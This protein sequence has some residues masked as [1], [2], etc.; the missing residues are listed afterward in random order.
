VV[1]VLIREHQGSS[2]HRC[3]LFPARLR[4]LENLHFQVVHRHIRG[5]QVAI[6][7]VDQAPHRFDL[8]FIILCSFNPSGENRGIRSKL[9]SDELD[10]HR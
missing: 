7:I 3:N 4:E 6:A 8:G 10:E 2:K 1:K 9:N 5:E